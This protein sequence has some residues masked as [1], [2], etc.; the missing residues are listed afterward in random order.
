M[1]GGQLAALGGIA[2]GG[3]TQ[4]YSSYSLQAQRLCG[5]L[6]EHGG[7]VCVGHSWHMVDIK[8]VY[9]F[10][11]PRVAAIFAILCQSPLF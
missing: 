7:P 2:V 10:N 8:A 1:L 11:L 9:L 3:I 4:T 6:L 5:S